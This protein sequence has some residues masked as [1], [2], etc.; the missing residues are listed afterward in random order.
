MEE[1]E[2]LSTV[3]ETARRLRLK[4]GTVRKFLRNG[5]LGK[6]KIG[7]RTLIL[8]SEIDRLIE[9]GTHRAR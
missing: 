1:K 5:V 3:N 7:S 8:S 4:P 2:Q 6:V 9:K